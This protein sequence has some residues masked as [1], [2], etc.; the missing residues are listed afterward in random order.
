MLCT[1]DVTS[2]NRLLVAAGLFVTR[3]HKHQTQTHGCHSGAFNAA[4]LRNFQ[5]H[6][7]SETSAVK[8]RFTLQSDVISLS[9][10]PA[11]LLVSLLNTIKYFITSF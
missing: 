6:R 2:I 8:G 4:G 9:A 1:S 7:D 11:F 10:A 5:G 3:R